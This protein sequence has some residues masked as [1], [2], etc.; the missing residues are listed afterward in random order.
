MS[1]TKNTETSAMLAWMW[2]R[3]GMPQLQWEGT[4]VQQP[5]KAVGRFLK[6]RKWSRAAIWSTRVIP[7]ST[8]EI[9]KQHARLPTIHSKLL[10]NWL[11][12]LWGDKWIKMH[13]IHNKE[14]SFSGKEKWDFVRGRKVDGTEQHH[15][16]QNSQTQTIKHFLLSLM[17]ENWNINK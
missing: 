16:K 8:A 11:R 9:I 4:G 13:H 1:A 7:Y 2:G 14:M 15:I 17:W 3:T 5:G 10:C 6:N 12:G